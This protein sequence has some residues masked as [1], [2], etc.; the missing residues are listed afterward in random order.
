MTV[1]VIIGYSTNLLISRIPIH[2]IRLAMIS[3]MN[4]TAPTAISAAQKARYTYVT[5]AITVTTNSGKTRARA[6]K[7][8]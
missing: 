5:K 8:V 1:I 4:T 7:F 3:A 6:R 2:R